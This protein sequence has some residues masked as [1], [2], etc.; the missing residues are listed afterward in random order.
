MTRDYYGQ[1][2][3]TVPLPWWGKL[4]PDEVEQIQYWLPR[5]AEMRRIWG[6]EYQDQY[7]VEELDER[8]TPH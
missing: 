3:T 8:C 4:Y 2:I 5:S 7:T 6:V 1:D